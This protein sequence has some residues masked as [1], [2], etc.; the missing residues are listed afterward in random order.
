LE[1]L[2]AHQVPTQRSKAKVQMRLRTIRGPQSLRAAHLVEE[3]LHYPID[4][5]S[6]SS[7]FRRLNGEKINNRTSSVADVLHLAIVPADRSKLRVEPT[8]RA[9]APRR[10]HI[11]AEHD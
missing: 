5:D 1:N 8:L 4:G 6:R 3:R 9:R 10:E 11:L 7:F 2:G